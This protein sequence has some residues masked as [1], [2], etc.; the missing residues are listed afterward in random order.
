MRDNM[1]PNEIYMS[2]DEFYWHKLDNGVTFFFPKIHNELMINKTVLMVSQRT[3]KTVKFR[4][5]QKSDNNKKI[6]N[7][8]G[9]FE[10]LD[11]YL[12]DGKRS[13]HWWLPYESSNYNYRIFMGV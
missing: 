1:E 12:G 4:Y 6:G 9:F 7:I 3:G 8:T 13:F 10:M 11:H 2:G 5:M